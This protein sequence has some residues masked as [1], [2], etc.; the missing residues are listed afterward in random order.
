MKQFFKEM[1][2]MFFLCVL[3]FIIASFKPFGSQ[4]NE[5]YIGQVGANVTVT[6]VQDGQNNRISTK[7][8]AQSPATLYGKNQTITFTQTGDNN[9][10]GLYKHYYGS[11]NQTSSTM[12]A[13]QSGDNNIMYLD[14][15]GDN[16][17]FDAYQLHNNAV[18]DLEIDYDD[19]SVIAKQACS[20]TSCNRDTMILNI[21]QADDNN[22]KMGQGYKIDGSG[23]FSY[24]NLELGGHNMDLY[25]TGDRNNIMLSQ[26]SSN[27]SSGH[28]MDIN[29]F[30]DDNNVHIIQEH[31][32]SKDL[33]LTLNNDDNN[34]DINQKKNFEH[35]ATVTLGG[36]YGT[37]FSL[38]QGSNQSTSAQSYSLNQNCQTSGGCSVSVTQY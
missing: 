12:T 19:N 27:N 29:I 10:I 18:M 23:N 28:D 14:N 25:M 26:R 21:Y 9:R 22:V 20:A 34:V 1:R 38:Q 4:A 6:I 16:N 11:D 36:N 31:N 30:S 35:T 15:H 8:T 17:N 3:I 33:T 2:L 5:I 7:S 37:D 32:S 24:D 13:I